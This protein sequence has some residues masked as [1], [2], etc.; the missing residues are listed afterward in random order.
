MRSTVTPLLPSKDNGLP[1]NIVHPVG[2]LGV[3]TA[4]VEE[5]EILEGHAIDDSGIVDDQHVY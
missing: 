5:V 2:D 1:Q 3:P 4:H